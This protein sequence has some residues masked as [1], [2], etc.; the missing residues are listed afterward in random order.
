MTGVCAHPLCTRP[1]TRLGCHMHMAALPDR[2]RLAVIADVD[3]A[4]LEAVRYWR[5]H[6]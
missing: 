3:G 4:T 2:V 6:P 5:D 1:T